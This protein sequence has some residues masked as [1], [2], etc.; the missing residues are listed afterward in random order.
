MDNSQ[1]GIGSFAYRYQ[2]GFPGCMPDVPLMPFDFI[3]AV[4][5]LGLKRLQLCENIKYADL[6]TKAI[7]LMADRTKELGL[8]VEIGMNGITRENLRKHI[9]LA[10]KF[11]SKFIRAVIGALDPNEN[12]VV[13]IA[14]GN[15]KSTLSELRENGS[16]KFVYLTLSA[17]F[18]CYARRKS[19]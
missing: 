10:K 1:L 5:R 12:K 13:Q 19:R 17:P 14:A 15:I 6:D 7:S 3:N 9:D 16:Q 8:A 4:Q 11:E 18:L 2:V